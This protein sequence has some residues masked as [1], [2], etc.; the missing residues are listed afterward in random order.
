MTLPH[1][2][3]TSAPMQKDNLPAVNSPHSQERS[4]A[5]KST[6]NHLYKKTQNTGQT[7]L[8]IGETP[9]CPKYTHTTNITS[10]DRIKINILSNQ[11][12]KYKIQTKQNKQIR[13]HPQTAVLK[14]K[15]NQHLK[16]TCIYI[17]TTAFRLARAHQ[18]TAAHIA[19]FNQ[20]T[21]AAHAPPPQT[22]ALPMPRVPTTPT[23]GC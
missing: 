3:H 23:E 14:I 12:F 8:K 10:K 15:F 19:R 13:Q 16:T 17:H 22:P 20:F 9:A 5:Q 4:K 2:S 7:H 11:P 18:L 6:F 21:T 1:Q